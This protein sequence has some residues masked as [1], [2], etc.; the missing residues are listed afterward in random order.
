MNC[1]LVA[2]T[3]FEIAPLLAKYREGKLS[4][5]HTIDV[6]IS[7]VGLMATTYSLQKQFTIKTPSLVIQAG[8]AGSFDPEIS[9][10]ET[11]VISKDCIA[12]E[13]VL[14]AGQL[15]TVFDMG[16]AARNKHPYKKGWLINPY[17]ELIKATGLKKA[18]GISVNQ[19]TTSKKMIGLYRDKFNA[20][21]ESMEGSAL[22]YVCLREQIPFV[23]LRSISNYVGDRNKR[24]W[25]IKDSISTLN[26]ALIGLLESMDINFAS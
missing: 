21:T 16:F 9:L 23:Q 24:N 15:S 26:K 12:D 14:E 20:T 4:A 25:R 3:A 7:G 5:N 10:T 11:R 8:I 6:L 19:I 17:K 18:T 22:H 2:A 1:L 13:G